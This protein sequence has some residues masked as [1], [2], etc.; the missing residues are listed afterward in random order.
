MLRKEFTGGEQDLAAVEKERKKRIY[1]EMRAN[2]RCKRKKRKKKKKK[3]LWRLS[4]NRP[5]N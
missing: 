5:R 3:V 4:E 2:P 1:G